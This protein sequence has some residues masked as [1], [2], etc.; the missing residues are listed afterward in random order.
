MARYRVALLDLDGVVYVGDQA[1]A[2]APAAVAAAREAGVRVGFITNNASRSAQEV[3]QLLSRRGVP[4]LEQEV[5]TSA[6]AAA[7]VL[8]GMLPP[9]AAVLVLGTDA[10]AASVRQAGLTP[11]RR[12]QEHPRAV[13]QGFSPT[14]DWPQLTQAALAIASGVP[15]VLTNA[16][17][18]IPVPEGL[19]PGNGSFAALLRAATGAQ[20]HAVTGKPQP[21]HMSLALQRFSCADSVDSVLM[22]GD[23]LDTDMAAAA[24]VGVDSLAVLTG[25]C[26]PAELV[27]A[28]G[29]QR[30]TYIA[31]SVQG[32]TQPLPPVASLY[33]ARPGQPVQVS[34]CSAH[35]VDARLHLSGHGPRIAALTAACAAAWSATDAGEVVEDLTALQT[36]ADVA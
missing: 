14:M 9:G 26:T 2:Q 7:Q 6:Q 21:E 33:P 13:V 23:R 22:V 3:A 12:A 17:L 1:I 32:L 5:V 28:T 25:V 34:G 24:A 19:A 30:P 31:Q 15:W 35:V 11:V 29:P 36:W 18:T 16:D 4:A 8:A 10:L 20:P 27:S